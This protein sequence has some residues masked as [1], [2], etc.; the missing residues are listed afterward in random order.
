MLVCLEGRQR[1]FVADASGFIRLGGCVSMTE[2]VG[3]EVA[4]ITIQVV[5]RHEQLK[6]E[7]R[8]N[9][10]VRDTSRVAILFIVV[11]VFAHLLEY[12]AIDVFK[13]ASVRL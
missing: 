7:L 5:G 2:S 1:R 12:H 4:W 3:G 10:Q 9:V 11:K 13:R 6:T 8:R